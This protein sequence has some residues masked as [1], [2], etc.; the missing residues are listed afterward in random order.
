VS[1]PP[2]LRFRKS[3]ATVARCR[4]I[5]VVLSATGLALPVLA[6]EPPPPPPRVWVNPGFY[7]YH[8]DR[9][10]D[11]RDRSF[12]L[13]VEVEASPRHALIAGSHANSNG[14]RSHYA[15]VLWR[16]LQWRGASGLRVTAGV[17]VAAVDGYPN[18]RHGRWFVAPLPVLS[19]EG[20]R[21]GLNL[22]LIPTLA[23]RTDGALALQVKL[24]V[25]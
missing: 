20:K 18:Y 23:N 17:A 8:F 6:E 5:L 13:G 11:L 22:G 3:A 12:G 19:I 9:D 16:P 1:P 21:L 2:C 24:R 10:K 15:G 4:K 14:A 25:W 7:A